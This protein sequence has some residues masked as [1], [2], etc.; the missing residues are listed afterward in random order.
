MPYLL[1]LHLL[2]AQN[3]PVFRSDFALVH[4]DAEVRQDGQPIAGLDAENFRV[5]D[6]GKPQTI[7]YFGH[8]EE[9]LDMVLLFDARG[10][11]RPDVKR[12][13]DAAH[14]ALGDLHPADHV[15]IMAI[16]RADHDCR[17]DLILD[18]TG[19]FESAEKSL[20][21][22]AFQQEFEPRG[23]S[24]YDDSAIQKG[25]SDA[26]RHLASQPTGNRKRAIIILTDD[27]G[28]P[29]R[30]E[31][32]RDAVHDLWKADAVVLGV[33]VHSSGFAICICPETYRGARY[34]AGMTG[35]D[36]LKTGDAVEALREMIRRLRSRYSLYYALPQ[37]RPGEERKIR[38]LL[39]PEAAKRNPRAMVRAR[40]G[41]VMPPAIH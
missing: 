35:G 41:Y 11:M 14:V 30:A 31:V 8:E 12:V 26:A 20:G 3:Q 34:D 36:I 19:D 6:N 37:G 40:T 7:L 2:L 23:W 1:L 9:P 32:A 25:L 21:G 39:T 28:T 29:A 16:A 24:C 10:A 17:T 18:F 13:A 4:V 15:A 27:K 5:T 22:D 33:I 38:V